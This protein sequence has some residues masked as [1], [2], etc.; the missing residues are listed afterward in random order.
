MGGGIT[1]AVNHHGADVSTM[2]IS[3][4]S[5]SGWF[6]LGANPTSKDPKDLVYT[7]KE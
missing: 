1:G 2:R 6:T 7:K 5:Q 4:V 3:G